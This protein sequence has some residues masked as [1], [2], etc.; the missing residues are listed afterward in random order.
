MKR[1]RET[2]HGIDAYFLIGLETSDSNNPEQIEAEYNTEENRQLTFRPLERIGIH[3]S[4]GTLNIRFNREN[5]R[6][7][8]TFT[9]TSDRWV[10]V[11]G[12]TV[13]FHK[14]DT[15]ILSI[16]EKPS[17][18][19]ITEMINK[20]GWEIVDQANEGNQRLIVVRQLEEQTRK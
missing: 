18:R 15:V 6:V 7:E 20:S 11:H 17:L 1:W 14:G 8:E 13:L 10:E 12:R 4:D 3:R 2:L 19:K 5:Q 16:T 9:F